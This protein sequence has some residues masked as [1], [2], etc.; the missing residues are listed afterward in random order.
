M[1]YN[2]DML[3]RIVCIDKKCKSQLLTFKGVKNVKKIIVVSIL[4]AIGITSIVPG[5]PVFAQNDTSFFDTFNI[6]KTDIST[7]KIRC[8]AYGLGEKSAYS[9][10]EKELIDVLITQLDSMSVVQNGTGPTVLK[11]LNGNMKI[12]G[13]GFEVSFKGQKSERTFW[14]ASSGEIAEYSSESGSLPKFTHQ[15]VNK[16]INNWL[17]KAE[18]ISRI[19]QSQ[20][21]NILLTDKDDI[22]VFI[23]V[24]DINMRLYFDAQPKVVNGSTMVPVRNVAEALGAH[25][26]WSEEKQEILLDREWSLILK[27]GNIIPVFQPKGDGIKLEVAPFV[28][29]GRT[30]VPLRFITE[31]FN[32]NVDYDDTTKTILITNPIIDG[33]CINKKGNYKIKIYEDYTFEGFLRP[34]LFGKTYESAS[35]VIPFYTDESLALPVT[36]IITAGRVSGS[37]NTIIDGITRKYAGYKNFTVNSI[38]QNETIICYEYNERE[39]NNGLSDAQRI[40]VNYLKSDNGSTLYAEVDSHVNYYESNKDKLVENLRTIQAIK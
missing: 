27:V 34:Q 31:F 40:S 21:Q 25:V 24:G 3:R 11:D 12:E 36:S 18:D 23:A 13:G 19:S 15:I 14:I 2:M 5:F 1:W 16:N 22:K 38:S 20:K 29:N 17:W 6:T 8:I 30:Y 7:M 32:K 4:I 9:L 39:I 26:Q 28:E 37:F 33:W 10:E 35:F